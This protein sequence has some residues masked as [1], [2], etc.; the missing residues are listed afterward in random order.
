MGE[1]TRE[2]VTMRGI[3]FIVDSKPSREEAEA[4]ANAAPLP[5][6]FIIDP[7]VLVALLV[8]AVILLS[9]AMLVQA[10]RRV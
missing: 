9:A 5:A 3:G 7:S 8:V 4:P 1:V 6:K 10:T 2:N